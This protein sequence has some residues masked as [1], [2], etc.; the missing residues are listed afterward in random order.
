MGL[1]SAVISFITISVAYIIIYAR[2][3]KIGTSMGVFGFLPYSALW[4][5][6][7]IAYIA[8]GLIIGIV[9]SAISIKK[10]LKV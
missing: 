6:I 10:Y 3:P 9:G 8:L 1:M 2:L 4:Y 5:Q 7:L